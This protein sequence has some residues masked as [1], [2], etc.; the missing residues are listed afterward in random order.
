MVRLAPLKVIILAFKRN[1]FSLLLEYV[2]KAETLPKEHEAFR[3]SVKEVLHSQL[4][5]HHRL[6]GRMDSGGL[7]TLYEQ[8]ALKAGTQ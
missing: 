8:E 2:E 4:G 5:N 7:W 1:G 3:T 6:G